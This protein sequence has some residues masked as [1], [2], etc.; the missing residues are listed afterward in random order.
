MGELH[1]EIKV[2]LLKRDHKVEV[3][4]GK[5]Q[6]AYKETIQKP[7][8]VEGKFIRQSG[9]RGQ[10]G[11]VWLKLEPI[12]RGK[13]FEFVNGIVGGLV[14][15][16]YIQAVEKGLTEAL[17]SGI[18]GG[19][20]VVD[21][22]ATLYDGSYHEVDSSEMA[23]KIAASMAF[24]SGMAKASPVLLEP[25]MKVEV[26]VPEEY[27]GDVIGSLNAKRGRILGM[28]AK[29]STHMILAEVPI[30]EMF[31]YATE[32][33]SMTKGRASYSMEFLRY[34]E[35]PTSVQNAVIEKK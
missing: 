16:E 30:G 26:E 20:P 24:K 35:V 2:D 32:L 19:Y 29:G 5:L 14:P 6:V 8:D 9:G 17:T 11:H 7:V 31:G 12:E 33:R 23:F 28:E 34:N 4:P 21:M 13:G 22:R 15:R 3:V 10:Y 25:I 18:L 27:M 1:L